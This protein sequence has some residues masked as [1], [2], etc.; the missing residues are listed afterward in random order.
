V[1]FLLPIPLSFV[2]AVVW[3]MWVSRPRRPVDAIDSVAEYRRALER[4]APE[5]ARELVRTSR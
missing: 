1:L 3:A 5:P 4:L 2:L